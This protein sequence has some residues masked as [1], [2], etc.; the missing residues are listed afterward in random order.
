MVFYYTYSFL[1]HDVLYYYLMH[2]LR[3]LVDGVYKII[4]MDGAGARIAL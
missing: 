4:G 2:L 1:D 3:Y